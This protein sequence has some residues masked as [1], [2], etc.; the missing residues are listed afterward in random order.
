MKKKLALVLGTRPEI[1]KFWP[2][3]QRLLASEV[4]EPCVISTGQH[5]ELGEKAFDCLGYQADLNLELMRPGQTLVQLLGRA[6]NALEK[7]LQE[8]APDCV[9]VQGDTTS[10][11]A[12]ALAAYHLKIPLA[13]VEAGLRTHDP[14]Q[15]FPEEMNR[16]MIAR[17]AK[18]HFCP[19]PAAAENLKN[20]GIEDG[21]FTVG[22]TCV[23]AALQMSKM[24]DEGLYQPE[25]ILNELCLNAQQY[26]LVT[27]HRRENF[28]QPINNLCRGLV[29]LHQHFSKLKIV[30]PVHLNPNIQGPV[31]RLLADKER[32]HLLP[33]LDYPSSIYLIQNSSLIVTD[34]GGIQ[35]E[36]PSFG[37]RVLVTRR[38][39]ERP[40]ALESGIAR[41]APLD[42][43]EEFVSAVSEELLKQ[44]KENHGVQDNNPFGD[45]N[46]SRQIV[47][48]LEQHLAAC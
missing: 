18:L 29:E 9:L 24:L 2:L 7:V 19:T 31:N 37:T 27:G 30:F 20:E 47:Q 3:H 13:H 46:T 4:L 6:I 32:I 40:E 22:N 34:S 10:A 28:D 12:G 17:L 15:P 44:K 8:T 14:M 25:P 43:V 5:K 11:L 16:V 21:V 41:L 45:G 1:I 33:P 38:S 48:I 35:E 26:L 36:A 39:T 23:D 42:S